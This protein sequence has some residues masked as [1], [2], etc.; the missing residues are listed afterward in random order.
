M[1]LKEKIALI[2]GGG[3]GIGKATALLFAREGAIVIVTGRRE[4]KLK[5]TVEAVQQEGGKAYYV[6]GDISKVEDTE[7]IIEETATNCGGLDIL[8]N[9]AGVFKGI[10]VTETSEQ[11]YDR[12][13]DIN[14]KGTFF[15]SKHAIPEIKKRGGGAIVNIGST[16][17]IKG[18]RQSTTSV[19]AAS[20]AGI[21]M[22]T[23]TLALELSPYKIRVNCICPAV[24]ETEIFETLGIPREK[25]PE[26]MKMWETFH[27]MGR[28]G[29]PEDIAY[30][31][32]YFASEDSSWATGSILNLD[33]GV[34]AE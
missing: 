16:L 19:Y 28:N 22:L 20:K 10:K 34:T 4:D 30:A 13:M 9:N 26:R 15:M 18:I 5:E 8:V 12:I 29:K 2:T 33:G 27:P 1:K 24:V 7:R 6:V 11:E 23:K 32:L 14:L 21:V 17:G 25:I 31:I 3:T